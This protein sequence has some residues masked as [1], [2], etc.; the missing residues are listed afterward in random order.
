MH[1]KIIMSTF[2]SELLIDE[3]NFQAYGVLL[4]LSRIRNP[5]REGNKITNV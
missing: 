5:N 2:A 4:T 1:N 3:H